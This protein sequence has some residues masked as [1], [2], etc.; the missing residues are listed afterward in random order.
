[1]NPDRM[2]AYRVTLCMQVPIENKT[3]IEY[4]SRPCMSFQSHE[5]LMQRTESN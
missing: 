1:M 4:T 2:H 3:F 5:W